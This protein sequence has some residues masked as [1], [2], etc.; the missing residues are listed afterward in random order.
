MP[1]RYRK[2]TVSWH[3]SAD[4]RFDPFSSLT[5]LAA[6]AGL[7][8]TP[9]KSKNPDRQS[10]RVDTVESSPVITP[11]EREARKNAIK[12]FRK[13]M[14]ADPKLAAK[15]VKMSADELAAALKAQ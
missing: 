2:L 6:S 10:L 15:L 11:E 8:V 13:L 14:R 12:N 7:V 5:S 3:T 4:G 9:G 1:A